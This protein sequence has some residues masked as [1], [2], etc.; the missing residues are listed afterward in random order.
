MMFIFSSVPPGKEDISCHQTVTASSH[1]LSSYSLTLLIFDAAKM[2]CWQ[3]HENKIQK[4]VYSAHYACAL[5]S[6]KYMWHA[7]IFLLFIQTSKYVLIWNC[8]LL[9]IDQNRIQMYIKVHGAMIQGVPGHF[10][11]TVP[12]SVIHTTCPETPCIIA[13]YFIY[14]CCTWTNLQ[15]T[16]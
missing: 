16:S 2:R 8:N 11:C 12:A 15:L 6:T 3:L 9:R 7:Q 1:V 14:S 13:P 10:M 5:S 4:N